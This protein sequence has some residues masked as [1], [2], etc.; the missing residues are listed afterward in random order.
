MRG[1][2]GD[3]GPHGAGRQGGPRVEEGG[4]KGRGWEQRAKAVRK[5]IV[6]SKMIPMSV[7]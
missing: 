4:V 5:E 2:A 3:S 1:E 7:R 6:E